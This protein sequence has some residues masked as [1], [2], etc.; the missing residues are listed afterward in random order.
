MARRKAPACPTRWPI[1]RGALFFLGFCHL[2][3]A[4]VHGI[5][6]QD[7]P[8]VPELPSTAA[9][10]LAA[11]DKSRGELER[12]LLLPLLHQEQELLKYCCSD[13]PRLRAVQSRI[14]CVRDFLA[15]HAS[16]SPDL[17]LATKISSTT[18]G[19]F[20]SATAA[21][22]LGIEFDRSVSLTKLAPCGP[23]SLVECSAP[24]ST[25]NLDRHEISLLASAKT[26][27]SSPTTPSK[28]GKEPSNQKTTGESVHG[29]LPGMETRVSVFNPNESELPKPADFEIAQ[30]VSNLD[31][32]SSTTFQTLMSKAKKSRTG[33]Y[34]KNV[35]SRDIV[36]LFAGALICLLIQSVAFYLSSRRKSARETLASQQ[37]GTRLPT[38]PSNALNSPSMQ[39]SS[40]GGELQVQKLGCFVSA[41]ASSPSTWAAVAEN[42]ENEGIRRKDAVFQDLAQRDGELRCAAIEMIVAC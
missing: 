14:A 29:I 22:R 5:A 37:S 35:S 39:V 30:A 34:F 13:H 15:V 36:V 18:E 7:R 10:P 26:V 23:A 16:P 12:E 33:G 40:P 24:V 19:E 20:Q 3:F 4:S 27:A 25:Q 8:Q 2:I 42:R 38:A 31:Q 28:S 6:A 21:S 1:S 41:V 9:R 11:S 32:E 17:R